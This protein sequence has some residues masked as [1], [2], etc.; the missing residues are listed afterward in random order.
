MMWPAPS[1]L[2]VPGWKRYYYNN[3]SHL[4][5]NQ[6]LLRL[7]YAISSKVNSYFW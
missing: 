1:R 4:L 6:N 7:D 5:K 3:P 2:M